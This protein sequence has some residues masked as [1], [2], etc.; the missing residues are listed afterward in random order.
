V[1][2]SDAKAY[3]AWLSRKTGKTYRLLSEA[4][5]EYAARVGTTTPYAFG[6]KILDWPAGT[7]RAQYGTKMTAEGRL[8][9]GEQVRP[10]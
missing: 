7:F 6:D 8:L 5:W 10:P 9:P 1:D 4:E 3:T 2:W